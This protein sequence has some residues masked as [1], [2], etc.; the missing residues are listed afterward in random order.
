MG[1]FLWRAPTCHVAQRRREP[2][3]PRDG[4]PLVRGRR[5]ERSRNSWRV[6]SGY[7]VLIGWCRRSMFGFGT[8]AGLFRPLSIATIPSPANVIFSSPRAGASLQSDALSV[9]RRATAATGSHAQR[10]RERHPTS[11]HRGKKAASAL[12]SVSVRSPAPMPPRPFL[13]FPQHFSRGVSFNDEIV[14]PR[15]RE[16]PSTCDLATFVSPGTGKRE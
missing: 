7:A 10:Q 1:Y 14:R 12:V 8:L 16:G 6:A 3:D 13:A 4:R 2:A 9:A 15:Q 11:R 5:G